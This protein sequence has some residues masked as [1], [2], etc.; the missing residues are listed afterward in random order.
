MEMTAAFPLA[1]LF[2]SQE[3]IGRVSGESL[4]NPICMIL[5]CLFENRVMVRQS[6]SFV[7]PELAGQKCSRLCDMRFQYPI[8]ASVIVGWIEGLQMGIMGTIKL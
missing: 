3:A 6:L 7:N 8:I 2:Q 4:T 1:W 5:H